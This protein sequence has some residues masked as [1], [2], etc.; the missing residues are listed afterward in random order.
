MGPVAGK[1]NK[2]D[3]LFAHYII[4]VFGLPRTSCHT[5]IL[6]C[7]GRRC[8]MCDSLFLASIQLARG[9]LS[10]EELWGSV[11]NA[12]KENSLKGSKWFKKVTGGLVE[13]ELKNKIWETPTQVL[14]ERKELGVTFSQ[15]CFH[16]HLN[17]P[18]GTSADRI[19]GLQPFGMYPFL[20][21][22]SPGLSRYLFSF[23][24]LSW[25]WLNRGQCSRYPHDCSDCSV[26]NC[27]AHLLFECKNFETERE[28]FFQS[29]GVPFDFDC[30]TRDDV[31]ISRAAVKLGKEIFVKVSRLCE[32]R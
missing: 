28:G 11:A 2:F 29:T 30:L 8:A 32:R 10:P 6:A 20:L 4:W 23:I 24:L 13:R 3:Q 5:A 14:A 25:R 31:T 9:F 21:H 27:S 19:R 18:R 15:F 26:H 17:L 22:T 7:F 1:L 16:R 12:L